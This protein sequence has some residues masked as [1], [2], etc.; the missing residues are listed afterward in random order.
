[1][2]CQLITAKGFPPNRVHRKSKK[3]PRKV[4][5]SK[6]IIPFGGYPTALGTRLHPMSLVLIKNATYDAVSLKS[7]MFDLLDT[8]IPNHIKTG[9]RT[10]I[11]PNFLTTAT[12]EQGITTHPLIIR[13]TVEYVLEKGGRPLVA[14]SP[15]TRSFRRLMKIGGYQDALADLPVPIRP[16]NETVKKDI[17]K[18]FGQI[19]LAADAVNT[20]VVI[21]LAK[22]K[23][24]LQMVLTLGVKNLF[25]CV[26]GLKKPEWHMRSGVDRQLFA[27]LLVQICQTIAPAVT[28]VDGILAL[29]GQ[30]PGKGGQP[31]EL[32]VLLAGTSAPAVDLA[33]ANMLGIPPDSLP[34]HTAARQLG[35]IGEDLSIQGESPDVGQFKLPRLGS[36]T[37]G[38]KLF[39]K[40]MRKH[41]IQRP[42]VRADACQQCGECWRYCP[43]EAV[44]EGEEAVSFDYERCIRCYCCTEVCPHGALEAVETLPGRL[45]RKLPGLHL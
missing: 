32:N 6:F 38:P 13:A 27:R 8:L 37:F 14:D 31:R 44:S 39:Q 20:D 35:H 45:I 26:V 30:G 34:T 24:H 15:A 10:L 29:E 7:C 9:T 16:F 17:G 18:P 19:D 22:L 23:T 36:L 1:M 25:G 5:Y 42:K 40:Q 3:I 4:V 28:V 12:P 41:L 33:V 21:N 43:A 11:K 2:K